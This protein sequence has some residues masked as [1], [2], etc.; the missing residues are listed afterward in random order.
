MNFLFRWEEMQ[1]L[2]KNFWPP[3][4]LL[5]PISLSDLHNS[6]ISI[7]G[8]RSVNPEHIL[9]KSDMNQHCIAVETLIRSG[10]SYS[11]LMPT[12][13]KG[14]GNFVYIY[15]WVWSFMGRKA[16]YAHWN[17]PGIS[18]ACWKTCWHFGRP[19]LAWQFQKRLFNGMPGVPGQSGKPPIGFNGPSRGVKIKTGFHS[20]NTTTV[21]LIKDI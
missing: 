20:L 14:K 3:E 17:I 6:Q 7:N 18:E 13:W 12:R 15:Y 8:Q 4:N 5:V 21:I 10:R 9:G 11:Y 16:L 2:W 19:W 1:T